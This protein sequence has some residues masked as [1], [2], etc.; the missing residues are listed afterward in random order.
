MTTIVS[1]LPAS[2]NTAITS[3]SP[4]PTTQNAIL[5]HNTQRKRNANDSLLWL[6]EAYNTACGETALWVAV[7]TQAMMDAL[8]TP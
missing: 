1:N 3:N 2:S 8:D 5:T 4:L 7:I 6:H